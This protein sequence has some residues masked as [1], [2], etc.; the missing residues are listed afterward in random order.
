ME[1]T[2]QPQ[3]IDQTS[4]PPQQD[5]SMMN[6]Q[7]TTAETAMAPK[8]DGG[9]KKPMIMVLTAFVLGIVIT[10]VIVVLLLP[11]LNQNSD[12]ADNDSSDSVSEE[13]IMQDDSDD[14]VAETATPIPTEDSTKPADGVTPT[15]KSTSY[16]PFIIPDTSAPV[17]EAE[18]IGDNGFPGGSSTSFTLPEG[19]TVETSG[20]FGDKF[21]ETASDSNNTH[22]SVITYDRYDNPTPINCTETKTGSFTLFHPLIGENQVKPWKVCLA[23]DDFAEVYWLAVQINDYQVLSGTLREDIAG[24]ETELTK[25]ITQFEKFAKTWQVTPY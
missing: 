8:S 14:L 10:L 19:F 1:D 16:D 20:N 7:P 4:V 25:A 15:A 18:F 2:S 23:A 22:F 5:Q 24:N 12:T 9:S 3:Q 6:Q 17:V 21:Q 13:E 11:M